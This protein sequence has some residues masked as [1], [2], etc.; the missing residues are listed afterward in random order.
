LRVIDEAIGLGVVQIGFSGGEP[1]LAAA[2]TRR[3]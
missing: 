3:A 1:T 2:R